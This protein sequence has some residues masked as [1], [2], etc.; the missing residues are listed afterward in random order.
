[1]SQDFHFPSASL[2]LLYARKKRINLFGL[3][4]KIEAIAGFTIDAAYSLD[5]D[6]LESGSWHGESWNGLQGLEASAGVD[7]SILNGNLYLVGQYLYNGPGMLAPGDELDRLYATG[8]VP[9]DEIAPVER[10]A[11]SGTRPGGL[12]R[13][14]YL[15]A[16]MVYRIDDYTSAGLSTVVSLDDASFLPA[17]SLEFELFQGMDLT[18]EGRAPLD[19]AVFFPKNSPGELGPTHSGLRTELSARAK[20]RF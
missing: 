13:S 7:Y 19:A 10:I 11:A 3:S 17:L 9:W 6:V 16:A 5:E 8:S 4:A 1:M 15:Y 18:F 2:Q 14:N 12:N 20:L